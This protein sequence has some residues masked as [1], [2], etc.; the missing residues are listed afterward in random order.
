[1]K[2]DDKK[3]VH[4]W[5]P[6]NFNKAHEKD[7]LNKRV[8][9]AFGYEFLEVDKERFDDE[10]YILHEVIPKLSIGVFVRDE[11][12]M[13]DSGTDKLVRNLNSYGLHAFEIGSEGIFKLLNIE[14][15]EGNLLNK[16]I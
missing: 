13:F 12:G 15:A 9:N 16:I 5:Y 2:R 6:T 10:N 14:T 1:M 4:I 7:R 3:R 8:K 11:N